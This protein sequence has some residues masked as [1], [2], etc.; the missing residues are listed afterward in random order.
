MATM[1]FQRAAEFHADHIAVGVNAETGIAE[2]LLHG[3]QESG[4]RRGDGDRRGIAARNFLS[5]GR[6]AECS[7]RG[8]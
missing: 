2:F 3:A 5:E 6:T 7:D 1:F 4:I 8:S